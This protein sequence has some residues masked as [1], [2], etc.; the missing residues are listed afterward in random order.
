MPRIAKKPPLPTPA[1]E[2]P[3]QPPRARSSWWVYLV[4]LIFIIGTALIVANV[5][6]KGEGVE[7]PRVEESKAKE[8]EKLF[9]YLSVVTVNKQADHYLG[10]DEECM[11]PAV[12]DAPKSISAPL[13]FVVH[14][15]A[16]ADSDTITPLI[17]LLN[18]HHLVATI[19]LSAA[20][21]EA[22]KWHKQGHEISL[23]VDESR[24][25]A[26]ETGEPAYG[27]SLTRLHDS[28]G[29]L[30]SA[31]DCQ[32]SSWSGGD[33][34]KNMFAVAGELG[35]T[36][37]Y[38][39]HDELSHIP[40][41]LAVTN[42]WTPSGGG[43]AEV[44]TQFNPKG[45]IVFMPSGVYPSQCS[46]NSFGLISRA[47]SESLTASVNGKVNAFVMTLHASDFT[48]PQRLDELSAWLTTTID[49]LVTK[50]SLRPA[51]VSA[52]SKFYKDW[53]SHVA[54]TIEPVYLQ[55]P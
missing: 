17:E 46:Q 22:A 11:T 55:V 42:P 27:T 36:T 48:E 2:G 18:A 31:C 8:E 41:V 39:W 23:E 3:V 21:P 44:L 7:G 50:R 49:P 19:G 43:S 6:R 37:T 10:T 1:Q 45:E 28:L 33:A 25:F 32:V 30:Q 5:F 20:T 53:A 4:M 24:L 40:E 15:D 16:D 13:S 14:V 9:S 34:Y 47:L 26:E 12:V 51:T 29:E 38:D 35:L 52:V 54:G